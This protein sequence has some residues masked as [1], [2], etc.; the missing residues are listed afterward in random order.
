MRSDEGAQLARA[1]D[2]AF[3][4]SDLII[5]RDLGDLVAVLL[6]EV[7]LYRSM[8]ANHDLVLAALGSWKHIEAS[9]AKRVARVEHRVIDEQSLEHG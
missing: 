5:W 2:A 3:V 9:S 7:A 4:V 1:F 8:A 6:E